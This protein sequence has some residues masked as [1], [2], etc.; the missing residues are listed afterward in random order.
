[1]FKTEE[2]GEM[3]DLAFTKEAY[4]KIITKQM[5]EDMKRLLKSF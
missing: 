1:M 5:R 4:G 3:S 2:M